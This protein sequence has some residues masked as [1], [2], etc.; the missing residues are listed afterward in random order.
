MS[1]TRDDK[2]GSYPALCPT[3]PAAFV[4]YLGSPVE[5]RKT[6][7]FRNGVSTT[8]PR[9]D[10]SARDAHG[11]KH[12]RL[13]QDSAIAAP[14]VVEDISPTPVGY[15][16]PRHVFASPATV[17]KYNSPAPADYAFPAPVFVS[18]APV[19]GAAYAEPA[20]VFASSALVVKY[21]SPAP[22]V[23]GVASAPG[24]ATPALLV[25]CP[26]PAPGV[27]FLWPCAQ[28]HGRRRRPPQK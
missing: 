3:Y 21:I 10:E 2:N 27:D 20:P 6:G 5:Y 18:P 16:D 1:V 22:A 28:A 19:V 17:V 12:G 24:V 14:P 4:L 9:D 15:A 26:T 11:R 13:A 23:S 7:F 8:A 25:E